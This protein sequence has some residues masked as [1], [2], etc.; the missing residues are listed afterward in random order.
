MMPCRNGHPFGPNVV[1]DANAGTGFYCPECCDPLSEPQRSRTDRRAHRVVR[2]RKVLT[3]W[4]A[5][6]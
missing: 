6:A 2:I 5:R 4:G 1:Y 3:G